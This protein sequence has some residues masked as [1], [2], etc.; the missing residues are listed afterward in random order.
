ASLPAQGF[1]D[2]GWHF[3]TGAFGGLGSLSTH[4]LVDQG[5]SR[6]SLLAP[7]CPHDGEQLIDTLKQQYGCEI[8]W[9]ACDISDQAA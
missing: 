2:S 8:R 4:L 1:K 6:I 5:A 3:V 9:V 7:R